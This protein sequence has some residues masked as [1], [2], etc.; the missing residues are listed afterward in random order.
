MKNDDGKVFIKFEKMESDFLEFTVCC[1]CKVKNAAS[2]HLTDDRKKI[3][4]LGNY[5]SSNAITEDRLQEMFVSV[6][7]LTVL[8]VG[9]I[10]CIF[11]E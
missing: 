8:R 11:I 3:E 4:A 7:C 1:V 2:L 6:I 5:I 10:L 9:T